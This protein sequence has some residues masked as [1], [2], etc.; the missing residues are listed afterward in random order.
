[1]TLTQQRWYLNLDR[2][3][4]YILFPAKRSCVTDASF[5]AVSTFV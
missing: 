4:F 2:N 5:L 1:M 3:S